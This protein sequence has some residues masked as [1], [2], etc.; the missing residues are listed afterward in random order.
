MKVST[1]SNLPALWLLATVLF[2]AGCSQQP[3]ESAPVYDAN[4][5][6]SIVPA[7]CRNFFD[8]CNNCTRMAGSEEAACTRMA[9]ETY[10]KP[11]CVE[12]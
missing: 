12:H 10:Q 8:G 6:K 4:S 3:A 2:V 1:C 5:W 7:D 11:R 9:C